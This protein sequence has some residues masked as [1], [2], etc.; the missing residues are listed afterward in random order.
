VILSP[1]RPTPARAPAT[2]RHTAAVPPRVPAAV[3]RVLGLLGVLAALVLAL[4]LRLPDLDVPSSNYDEGVYLESLLLMRH[5]FRPFLDIVTTQGPLH[6]HLAYIPYALG[7]FTLSAARLGSVI[8]SAIALV[9]V[10]W[11]AG[12]LAGPAAAIGAAVVLA[13]SPTVLGVSRQTLP[14][15]PALALIS[16]AVAT[17]LMAWRTD[18]DRWRALSGLLLGLACLVKPVVAPAALP[19]LLLALS[20]RSPWSSVAAP[21]V[22]GVVG[23]AGIALVGGWVAFEQVIGWR[24]GGRQLDPS[25]VVLADN[26]DLLIDKMFRQERPAMY[27]LAAAG[28]VFLARRSRLLGFALIG[29]LGAQLALLLAYVNL[30]SHL[31]VILVAPLAIL[32]GVAVAAGWSA[33]S[34]LQWRDGRIVAA[35]LSLWYAISVPYL[36][37]RAERIVDGELSFSRELSRSER[38]IVRTMARS[39]G[40]DDWVITDAPYLAFLA[41]RKVPPSLVDPS[42]ARITSGALTDEQAI[43]VLH[44]YRPELVVLWSGKLAS[45]RRFSAT[46]ADELEVADTYGT[47]DD[48]LPR[49]VY[50]D[51]D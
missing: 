7:G 19:V 45:L 41:D 3:Q 25:W 32:F 16:L 15:A 14:E 2:D 46:V 44:D 28:G 36:L 22:A 34:G 10:A 50:R 4:W 26:A 29:W 33:L 13:L 40:P 12:V 51:P 24:V 35:G 27:A 23:L 38:E 43:A 11:S 18:R 39:T 21:L 37:D 47:V 5:G 20:R 42:E 30:S 17:A 1:D 48:G 49:A 9:G 8:A 31:G 6:L